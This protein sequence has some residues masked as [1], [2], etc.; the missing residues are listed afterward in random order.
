MMVGVVDSAL[1]SFNCRPRPQRVVND[2][3]IPPG[4]PDIRP[5]IN[6]RNQEDN[7]LRFK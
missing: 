5:V 7:I 6:S 2:G 4:I 1:T 3:E